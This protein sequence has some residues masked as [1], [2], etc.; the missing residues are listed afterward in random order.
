MVTR[1]QT[2]DAGTLVLVARAERD[3][4]G[5]AEPFPARLHC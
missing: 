5:W 1:G 3:S 2:A 4:A